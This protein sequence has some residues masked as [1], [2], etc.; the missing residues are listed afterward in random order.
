MGCIKA[1]AASFDN[2][3]EP[4]MQAQCRASAS[5]TAEAAAA[6]AASAREALL[7]SASTATDD[8]TATEAS[9]GSQ[10]PSAGADA[11]TSSPSMTDRTSASSRLVSLAANINLATTFSAESVL[12]TAKPLLRPFPASKRP[13]MQ[14]QTTACRAALCIKETYSQPIAL[15]YVADIVT[16]IIWLSMAIDWRGGI[17][18]RQRRHSQSSNST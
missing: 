7:L 18:A 5:P 3:G 4:V 8:G 10:T 1:R 15:K 16:T 6:A 12:A 11:K 9:P 14:H 13:E 17:C 2:R